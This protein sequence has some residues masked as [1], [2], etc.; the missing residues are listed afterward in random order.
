MDGEAYMKCV[1]VQ[2]HPTFCKR[3]I[4]CSESLIR[5]LY[6]FEHPVREAYSPQK[7]AMLGIQGAN[8]ANEVALLI[9]EEEPVAAIVQSTAL[10]PSLTA[11]LQESRYLDLVAVGFDELESLLHQ[12]KLIN[13]VA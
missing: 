8:P 7:P 13:L 4:D 3:F 5:I 2:V 10:T 6:A 12:Y 9:P 1:A 11:C